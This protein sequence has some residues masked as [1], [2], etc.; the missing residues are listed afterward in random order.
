MPS[1]GSALDPPATLRA[2]AS[3]PPSAVVGGSAAFPDGGV[4]EVG[5]ARLGDADAVHDGQLTGVPAC[6]E[7]TEARVEGVL[8]VEIVDPVERDT[9][10]GPQPFGSGGRSRG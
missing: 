1:K 9:R 5:E 6:G 4:D 8:A 7:M 3:Q 10:A 2:R